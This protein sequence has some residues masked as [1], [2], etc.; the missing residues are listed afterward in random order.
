MKS[1]FPIF[2]LLAILTSCNE[3]TS[4]DNSQAQIDSLTTVTNSLQLELT[5]YK[6]QIDS[7]TQIDLINDIIDSLEYALKRKDVRFS[8]LTQSQVGEFQR[9][10]E[11]DKNETW[12][13]EYRIDVFGSE[14]YKSV[15]L[16][17]I[18]YFSESIRRIGSTYE[19]EL[20][21]F[22]ERTNSLEFVKWLSPTEFQLA[23]RDSTYTLEILGPTNVKTK[24]P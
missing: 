8:A 3:P 1:I 11:E 16:T 4:S 5:K 14:V 6:L 23:T 17:K 9:L 2:L 20:D 10:E 12:A 18:E 15:Y 21:L 7:L 13:F 19:L 22:G 24:K